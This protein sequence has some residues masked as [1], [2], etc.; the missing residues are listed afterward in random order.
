MMKPFL[1]REAEVN[2]NF[3]LSFKKAY[4]ILEL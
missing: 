1:V 4:K 3:L 2:G